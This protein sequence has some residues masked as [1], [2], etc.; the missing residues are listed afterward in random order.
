MQLRTLL[1][2]NKKSFIIYIIGAFLTTPS[3]VLMTLALSFSFKLLD[4][5]N[6]QEAL[7]IVGITVALAFTPIILQVISRKMRIGFMKDVLFDIRVMSY[8]K[9]LNTSVNDFSKESLE[10]YESQMIADINLFEQEFFLSLLNIIFTSGSYVLS[11]ML[12]FSIS[13]QLA[14]LTLAATVFIY[15]VTLIY[16]RTILES[17]VKVIEENMKYQKALTN[18]LNGLE[19][20]KLYQASERFKK[21]F[22]VDINRYESV[23]AEDYRKNQSL[24]NLISAIAFF[25]QSVAFIY[26]AFLF[27]KGNIEVNSMVIALSVV[28]TLVWT[29][30]SG[31]E[32]VNRFKS[33]L[34]IYDDL[35]K[36]TVENKEGQDF[37]FNDC[38]SLRNVSYAYKNKNVFKDISLDIKAKS[39]VLVTGESGSGKTSLINT[40]SKNLEDYKGSIKYDG[41][42]LHD[43]SYDSFIKKV[44]YVRQE[45][46]LFDKSI[47]DNIILNK[48]YDDEKFNRVLKDSALFDTVSNFVDKENHLLLDNGSNISGG[49]RQRINIARE[50]YQDKDFIIFDEPSASLDDAN[51][52]HIYESILALDKTVLIISHRHLEF[53]EG[54]VNQKIE[55]LKEVTYE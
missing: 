37:H 33:S 36:G 35:V 1:N 7:K 13:Y 12:L 9:L 5:S 6:T 54:H 31:M 40:L 45:H 34:L 11:M 32:R 38:L 8:D 2:K 28:G 20:I 43:I 52:K 39:K 4:V 19:T 53:L 48:D 18:I 42:E 21:V 22:T 25:V 24:S 47:K 23:K 16:E 49:Q 26:A 51:A 30:H 3:N 29:I 27:S 46:F 17:K 41:V 44:S 15:F 14:F 10:H 55:L 50:L